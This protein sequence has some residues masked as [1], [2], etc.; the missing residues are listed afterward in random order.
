MLSY[1]YGY[2]IRNKENV[3]KMTRLKR[4]SIV[5]ML[6]YVRLVY[7]SALFILLLIS[8][9]RLRI[10][11]RETVIENLERIPIIIYV[12]WA[13]F[14]IEMIMRF[15]P[16]KYESP[17]CQ[18]QFACN[19]IKSGRTDIVIHDNNSTVLVALIWIVFN[20]IFG[21][22]HMAGFLDDGIM[23]LLCSA[24]SVCDIIC[25]LFFCPFQ[26]WFMKNKCCSQ[27]RIYN[28]DYAMMFTPLFFVRKRYT[29]SL[30]VLSVALL[31]RWE[32]TFYLHPEWFSEN[33]NE[34]LR[35]VN[36]REKL[37]TH[38]KQLKSLWKQIEAYSAEKKRQLMK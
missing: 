21:A 15:F 37:C 14:V 23:I 28:W 8:Y 9:I 16:S 3:G 10:H 31:I 26:T 33:T 34:Y 1:Y 25:I 2:D 13:V 18:K 4:I 30:L 22:L 29:W 7:R 38:K 32:V 6:H 12:T 24:Y 27:C 5:S 11:S 35:C 20:G 19:Y 36:C 17:G